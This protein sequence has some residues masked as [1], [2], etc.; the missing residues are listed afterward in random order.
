MYGQQKFIV[1]ENGGKNTYSNIY[2]ALDAVS[3]ITNKD[4]YPTEGVEII[5]K[6]GYYKIDK[7]LLI[8]NKFSGTFQK[9]FVIRAENP[10]KVH[11]FGGDILKLE[12]FK[13]FNSVEAGFKLNDDR[14]NSK[15]RVLDLKRAGI[16]KRKPW[17]ICKA[18]L[19][20]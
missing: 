12:N 8:D 10:F 20:F 6:D 13:N 19:W 17:G 2:D 5:I 15:I 3:K 11:F 14:A 1:Q 4:G 18:W 7:Q 16:K 9:P